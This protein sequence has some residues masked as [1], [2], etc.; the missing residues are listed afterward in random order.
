MHHK[1]TTPWL[2]LSFATSSQNYSHTISVAILHFLRHVSKLLNLADTEISTKESSQKDPIL[3]YCRNYFFQFHLLHL[4]FVLFP[5]LQVQSDLWVSRWLYLFLPFYLLEL[6]FYFVLFIIYPHIQ[7]QSNLLGSSHWLFYLPDLSFY[8]V[9]PP[10]LQLQSDHWVS[11]FLQF[12]L[13]DH[14]FYFVLYPHF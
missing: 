10:H 7:Q 3:N 14:S 9:L 4:Y 1:K 8:F 6:S 5:H 12:H 13:P 11:L 2:S